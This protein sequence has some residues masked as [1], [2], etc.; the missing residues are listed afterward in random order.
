[1]ICASLAPCERFPT[2][3]FGPEKK[4]S[5]NNL[6]TYSHCTKN[7]SS[8]LFLRK[9]RGFCFSCLKPENLRKI[10]RLD[11]LPLRNVRGK[12]A[13]KWKLNQWSG[14][15]DKRSHIP[16]WERGKMIFKHT[17]WVGRAVSF[18]TIGLTS[19]WRVPSPHVAAK[20][21]QE[22]LVALPKCHQLLRRGGWWFLGASLSGPRVN[23]Y[24]WS[25]ITLPL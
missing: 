20:N 8:Y 4:E 16:H 15:P 2:H 11:L 6:A 14:P 9:L 18:E 10:L 21:T 25:V 22:L 19:C 17:N 3:T 1:M 12:V 7:V 5:T 13:C 24:T 23:R